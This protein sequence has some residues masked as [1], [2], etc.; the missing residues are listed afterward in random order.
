MSIVDGAIGCSDH[1]AEKHALFSEVMK[2]HTAMCAG[3]GSR[4][5]NGLLYHYIDTN[6]A[7]GRYEH[8]GV[9]LTGS[10][11]RA[12][13]A[14]RA[15]HLQFRACL[16]DKSSQFTNELQG[17][18]K[19][20]CA[21]RPEDWMAIDIYTGDN[22]EL[23]RRWCSAIHN[24]YGPSGWL[25]PAPY[26]LLFNDPNGMPDFPLLTELSSLTQLRRIDFLLYASATLIKRVHTVWKS[27]G[28]RSL[29]EHLDLMSKDIW[30]IREPVGHQQWT[31][32]LGTNFESIR[33]WKRGGFYRIDSAEGQVVLE[34]LNGRGVG[35]SARSRSVQLSL[36][37]A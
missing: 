36:T 16:I 31:F 9:L 20:F 23:A 4:I 21:Q 32:L 22:T 27:K 1:T 17:H 8:E 25:D 10:P 28:H 33:D 24:R 13:S 14:I 35:A 3:I 19:Q 37:V 30:L 11:L 34:R 18:V 15:A 6:A 7:K 5:P 2:W 26:G 29:C 12:L